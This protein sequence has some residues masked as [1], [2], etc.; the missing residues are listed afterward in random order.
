ML[1]SGIGWN[2]TLVM[3]LAP[4]P[5]EFSGRHVETSDSQL[6]QWFHPSSTKAYMIPNHPSK[7][8]LKIW[9]AKPKI[10]QTMA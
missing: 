5:W 3:T 9:L 1:P 7:L 4:K 8:A 10:G 6:F 2:N